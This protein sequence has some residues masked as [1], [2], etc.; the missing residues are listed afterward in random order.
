MPDLFASWTLWYV[1]GAIVVAI[2]ASVVV[3]ILLVAR[4]IEKEAARALAA[5]ARVKANTDAIFALADAL[6]GLEGVREV[7]GRVEAKAALLAAA[8]HQESAEAGSA[9]SGGVR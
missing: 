1:A 5:G 8:V 4:G 9:G 2:A 3:T 7:A 6:E